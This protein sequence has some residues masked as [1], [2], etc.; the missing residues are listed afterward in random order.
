M[1]KGRT[2]KRGATGRTGPAGPA[3]PTGAAGKRGATGR[4][5]A[6]GA[7]GPV[8]ALGPGADPRQLI[9]A[10]DMQVDGIYRELTAQ[11]NRMASVQSQLAEVRAA[12]RKLAG[13]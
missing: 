6:R 12:I 3:G 9:R 4:V 13:K 11:M 2:G 1:A 10:L 7:A 5:G 8:G